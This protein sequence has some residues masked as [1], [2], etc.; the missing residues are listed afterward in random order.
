MQPTL[1]LLA[2]L[3]AALN[4]VSAQP[5]PRQQRDNDNGDISLRLG[6]ILVGLG[7][8][9]AIR[10]AKPALAEDENAIKQRDDDDDVTVSLGPIHVGAATGL[11]AVRSAKPAIAGDETAL[12]RRDNDDDDISVTLGP[13]RLDL[14]NTLAIRSADPPIAI[15]EDENALK[16]RD[17][18][19]SS[20]PLVALL[21]R[22]TQNPSGILKQVLHF[23]TDVWAAA[24]DVLEKLPGKS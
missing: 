22:Q 5:L 15:A 19:A 23:P 18:D 13:L 14:T 16:Q 2:I 3:A 21:R 6:P 1:L 7:A 11:L 24:A 12:K 17:N 9:L 10:S 4:R 8:N 20:T